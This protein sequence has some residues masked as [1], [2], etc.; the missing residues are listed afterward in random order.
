MWV[1]VP[2]ED[3]IC[4]ARVWLCS[5]GITLL[6]AS[7]ISRAS[8]IQTYAQVVCCSLRSIL[9]PVQM[10]SRS[11]VLELKDLASQ[12]LWI[13]FLDVFV[14]V[15]IQVVICI[16]W[17]TV[18]PYRSTIVVLD[19]FHLTAEYHCQSDSLVCPHKKNPLT[20]SGL[21]GC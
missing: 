15:I 9:I 12:K 14:M 17:Q 13:T 19:D 8:Q 10:K 20:C 4:M 5:I 11:S 6:L 2:T 3:P 16:I 1:F 21:V 7:S 18:D